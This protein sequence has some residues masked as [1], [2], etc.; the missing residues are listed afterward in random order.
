MS[1]DYYR[2]TLNGS[3]VLSMFELDDGLWQEDSFDSNESASFDDATDKITVV[4]DY[5]SYREITVYAPVAG[6]D[7]YTRESETYV[8][9]AGNPITVQPGEI[10]DSNNDGFDDDDV[11]LDGFENDS[12]VGTDGNDR[13]YARGGD[14]EVSG[15]LGNDAVRGGRGDDDISGD[16]G[17]DR[18]FGDSGHDSLFGGTGN[19]HLNGGRGDDSLYDGAGRDRVIGGAGNDLFVAAGGNDIYQGSSGSDTVSYA[20][21]LDGVALNLQRG[22]AASADGSDADSASVGIDRLLNIENAIGSDFNDRLFGSA[23]NNTIDGGSGD[24]LIVGGHGRDLLTGGLGDDVFDFNKLTDSRIG[25]RADVVTD[26]SL[27]DT[28]DLSGID[29]IR[30]NKGND[31]FTFL[32]PDSLS[33]ANARGALWFEDGVLYGSVDRDVQ[34]EFQIKLVGVATLDAA[35]LI[36]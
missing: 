6:Q 17:N 10:N 31:A 18:L 23:R 22:R 30:G 3:N 11:D 16:E 1:S 34:S 4:E 27:G 25:T 24:D 20:F 5:G 35:D 8:D 2:F 7:Y 21:A 15:G 33:T 14:D 32:S 13:L 36:L 28:I 26:F 19:D 9:A 29:A 12:I